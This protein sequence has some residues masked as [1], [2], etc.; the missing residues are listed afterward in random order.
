M[1]EDIQ[2]ETKKRT[3]QRSRPYPPVS[4]DEALKFADIVDKLGAR[5]VSEPI[6][7]KKLVLTT[8]TK[9]FWG[10]TASAKQFGLMTVDG[11][12]YTLTDRARLILRPKDEG[13]KKNILIEA[14]LTPELYKG[15]YE[16]FREKQIPSVE[17][18][19]NIL[20]YDYSINVNVS[21]DAAKAFID[22]AKYVGLLGL[23]NVLREPTEGSEP[24][25][26]TEHKV[27][28]SGQVPSTIPP[29]L[30]T[31]TMK[32]SKGTASIMFPEGGITKKDCERLKKLIDAYIEEEES[33]DG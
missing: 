14:F 30:V 22:S 10:K 3:F 21:R 15:L 17:T 1:I 20:S 19:A 25:A 32:L 4:I 12:S 24:V 2:E 26:I 8:F 18:L 6:L 16:K 13:S 28:A 9:S 29:V 31:A 33:I 23:D 5:N 27:G 11:K 7:L